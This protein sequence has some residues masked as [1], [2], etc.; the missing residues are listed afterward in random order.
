MASTSWA[1]IPLWP[2]ER[3][4]H[5]TNRTMLWTALPGNIVVL[6]LES[7]TTSQL[8]VAVTLLF[9]PIFLLLMFLLS[10][11]LLYCLV[12]LGYYCCRP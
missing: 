7:F 10:H 5:T 3:F 2:V 11:A 6:S 8:A 1:R 12:M 4:T 9:P